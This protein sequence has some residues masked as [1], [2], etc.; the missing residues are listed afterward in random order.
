M[1]SKPLITLMVLCTVTVLFVTLDAAPVTPIPSFETFEK[2]QL[3]EM[4]RV[5][6]F[7]L[8]KSFA[9]FG[10][11]A[12][13][14]GSIQA[15]DT[16]DLERTFLD[17]T[18]SVIS[19]LRKKA[20][21][22][23][24]VEQTFFSGL[25]SILSLIRDQI[26]DKGGETQ[27]QADHEM[28]QT[29]GDHFST[30]L[31]AGM[32][33]EKT[34]NNDPGV[35]AQ[36]SA[37][38]KEMEHNI[39]NNARNLIAT[40]GRNADPNNEAIHTFV[41]GANTLLSLIGMPVNNRGEDPPINDITPRQA[42]MDLFYSFI[43]FVRKLINDT[44]GDSEVQLQ[45]FVNNEDFRRTALNIL[46]VLLSVGYRDINRANPNVDEMLPK[47]Y[48]L[49]KT[50][51]PILVNVGEHDN[52]R[53]Q[54]LMN[55]SS[56]FISVLTKMV[57][58]GKFQSH[59][60]SKFA[61]LRR[62]AVWK[63]FNDTFSAI[64]KDMDPDD[65]SPSLLGHFSTFLSTVG[66]KIFNVDISKGGSQIQSDT[67]NNFLIKTVL[68]L[69]GSGNSDHQKK[70]MSRD[71]SFAQPLFTLINM[72]LSAANKDRVIGGAQVVQHMDTSPS[73]YRAK[74]FDQKIHNIM[75]MDSEDE[76]AAMAGWGDMDLSE[77]AKSQL[78]GNILRGLSTGVHA[79]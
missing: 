32:M 9:A 66:R 72:M 7:L 2:Q 70:A 40:L 42:F 33:E 55:Q 63:I 75:W 3:E 39:L 8:R 22:D 41:N 10:D 16:G 31:S 27:F 46:K 53:L 23:D 19:A 14:D 13:R 21:S 71:E 11:R 43:P 52:E 25:S 35:L 38:N 65:M 30:L 4:E 54:K 18:N 57:E 69:M 36:R 34:E 6:N 56:D 49:F 17:V 37:S 1:N 67:D 79:K 61:A 58:N 64:T 12:Y 78:W 29:V 5:P 24:E 15:D 62:P 68:S 28:A 73:Q 26:D 76:N 51:L 74:H 77:E 44:Y 50:V 48:N 60:T 59:S 45:N 47:M 20:N